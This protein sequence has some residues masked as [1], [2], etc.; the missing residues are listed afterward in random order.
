MW[1]FSVIKLVVDAMFGIVGF[2]ALLCGILPHLPKWIEGKGA[3]M[4]KKYPYLK[5]ICLVIVGFTFAAY[6][7]SEVLVGI[8]ALNEESLQYQNQMIL[9]Y[10]VKNFSIDLSNFAENGASYLPQDDSLEVV[11]IPEINSYKRQLYAEGV[12]SKNLESFFEK[13][14]YI[15]TPLEQKT[16][17]I[18]IAIELGKM[19]DKL[20]SRD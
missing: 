15:S 11:Y 7:T 17:L 4:T 20:P 8:Q 2:A 1:I 10:H 19:A 5:R 18:E 14:R 9:K 6:F 13:H 12:R 16:N 3:A